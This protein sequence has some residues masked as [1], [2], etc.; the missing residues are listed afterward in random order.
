[1]KINKNINYS[2]TFLGFTPPAN[3]LT[4]ELMGV[5][6]AAVKGTGFG[7]WKRGRNPDR[8]Q[9]VKYGQADHARI[10]QDLPTHQATTIVVYLKWTT[11]GKWADGTYTRYESKQGFSVVDVRQRIAGALSAFYGEKGLITGDNLHHMITEIA[12][13]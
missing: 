2:R 12:G 9:F 13:G 3:S 8:F 7:I 4:A 5:I 10:R 11:T 1:M 6:S